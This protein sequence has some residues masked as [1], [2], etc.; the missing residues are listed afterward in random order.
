[1][2]KKKNIRKKYA[3][4]NP[5]RGGL[6]TREQE[7]SKRKVK[8]PKPPVQDNRSVPTNDLPKL[9][10]LEVNPWNESSNVPVDLS[11]N[12]G[13]LRGNKRYIQSIKVLGSVS[14]LNLEG[15]TTSSLE[16][17]CEQESLEVNFVEDSDG[18]YYDGYSLC[19]SYERAMAGIL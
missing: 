7:T 13:V 17:S 10:T 16:T 11:D 6:A 8:R 2:K 14:T 15:I 4:G 18:L 3:R 1:M 19:E 9:R 12:V 5:V